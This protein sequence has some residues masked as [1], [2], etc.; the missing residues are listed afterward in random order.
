MYY[1]I[2]CILHNDLIIIINQVLLSGT[3]ISYLDF[4]REGG[5]EHQGLTL[6]SWWHSI[7]FHDTTDLWLKSHVQHPIRLVQHQ[8]PGKTIPKINLSWSNYTAHEVSN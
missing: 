5:A 2:F 7:L 6:S 1:V 8:V 3:S 4:F